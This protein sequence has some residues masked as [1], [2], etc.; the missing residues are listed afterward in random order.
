M[1]AARKNASGRKTRA[2]GSLSEVVG[3]QIKHLRAEYGRTQE[4]VARA[5]E[6]YGL[7]WSR[8]TVVAIEGGRRKI[9]AEE[10]MLLPWV[11]S[12]LGDPFYDGDDLQFTLDDVLRDTVIKTGSGL[13]IDGVDAL[14]LLGGGS[15]LA[16][17]V[18]KGALQPR[19]DE[20]EYK[21]G[22]RL[23]MSVDDVR[24]F[25]LQCWSR[26]LT[27]ERDARLGER[28]DLKATSARR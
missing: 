18:G 24:F 25:S 12:A 13:T 28:D 16:R 5:A 4:D 21:A 26:P 14:V 9:E 1:A 20:A 15:R 6:R 22:Q 3:Q 27:E 17:P 2:T 10:L 19:Y 8:L 11:L 23:G 7:A